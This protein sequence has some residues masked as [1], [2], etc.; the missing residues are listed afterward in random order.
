V[1]QQINV[2]SVEEAHRLACQV[3]EQCITATL[4]K[5]GWGT[6][7]LTK[8]PMWARKWRMR[9]LTTVEHQDTGAFY[10]ARTSD[11]RVPLGPV[12]R[13]QLIVMPMPE[14]AQA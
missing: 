8:A 12:V 14:M 10:V 2:F 3:R 6:W 9:R 7:W 1:N 4:R 11:L 5:L 13:V